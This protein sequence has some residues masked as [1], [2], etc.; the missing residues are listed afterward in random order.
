MRELT[1]AQFLGL[2]KRHG[3]EVHA[4]NARLQV[5]APAGA[6]DSQ[7]REE[8]VRRKDDLLAVLTRSESNQDA[9]VRSE[10]TERIPQTCAQQRLWLIDRFEPGNVA[11][12]I[13]EAFVANAAIDR[14]ALQKAVDCLLARHE[15]LR[16]YFYQDDGELFQFVCPEATAKVG[17]TDLT[18]LAEGSRDQVLHS[19]IRE[20]A[21]L[22][23]V[24]H[25]APLIRFHLFRVAEQR[26]VIFF[27]THHIISDRRS[28]DI[29][30][31]EL[32][33]LYQAAVRN[34]KASLPDL[35]VQYA[36]YAI[37]ESRHL[38]G[39][40]IERQVQYWKRKLGGA[41]AC[42]EL[43]CSRP[44]PHKRTGWG[45]TVPVRISKPLRD[46][47]N[48][49]G[50]QEGASL[51]M[52]I[53]AA[54]AV[55]LYKYSGQE[56][57]CIGS[58]ITH[59]RQVQTESIIGLFVNMLAFRCELGGQPSFREFLRRVRQTAL[60]AYENSEIPFQ[61]LVSEL[62]P[63]RR[64][65]RSPVF[66]VMFGFDPANRTASDG[67]FQIDT[68]PGT[69]RFDLTLQLAENQEGLSGSFEYCTDIFEEAD[70]A[71]LV[72]LFSAL[73]PEMVRLPDKPISGLEIHSCEIDR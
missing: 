32:G 42:L 70:I 38:A 52:T 41:P 60:E 18:S 40:M 2:L 44:Y 30:R 45:A 19:L 12:N 67:L 39:R 28:L 9:L 54:F 27:N 48:D 26:H 5:T 23:F 71:R 49:I 55:L 21:R 10:R 15:A 65:R 3:I 59:R 13:P 1:H 69:A 11:Y 7:L 6:M 68:N 47:L 16:T 25:Q 58:P 31:E 33:V 73:L 8:L 36:D 14:E 17:F 24:L 22:P 43:P 4:R 20:Q 51:F 53:L 34:E 50:H 56:D 35:P 46:A 29:L 57:F 66:Q 37:W 61:K 62:K 63:D 64:S 72:E